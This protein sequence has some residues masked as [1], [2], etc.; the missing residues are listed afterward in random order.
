MARPKEHDAR[1]AAALLTAAERIVTHEGL[2]ALS[3]R[4]VAGAAGTTTRAVYSLF[5][6][7]EGLVIALGARTFDL[8]RGAIEALPLT[9]D[10]AADLVETGAVVFRRFALG[11][12]ALF[13]LGVQRVALS[14]DLAHRIIGTST[15]AQG[16][17]HARVARLAQAGLLGERG[18]SVATRQ[19][20]ALCEGLAAVELRGGLQDTDAEWLWRDA[21]TALVV[22]WR[23]PSTQSWVTRR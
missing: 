5:G 14:E 9:D 12:P 15:Q 21:L 10:P 8:L 16:H 19:F 23:G 6:S 1:T 18:V 7:R 17:L 22:G 2:D 11:H 13:R 4:A 3:V 20:H